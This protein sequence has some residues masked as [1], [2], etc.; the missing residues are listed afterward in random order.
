MVVSRKFHGRNSGS[1]ELE[2]SRGEP[3]SGTVVPEHYE[4]YRRVFQS[5]REGGLACVA[6]RNGIL[7]LRWSIVQVCGGR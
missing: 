7:G 2:A 5:L 6:Q 1:V 4:V 3:Q